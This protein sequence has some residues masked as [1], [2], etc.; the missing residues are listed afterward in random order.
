MKNFILLLLLG[1]S[2]SFAATI[3]DLEKAIY[4]S[5]LEQAEE[6]INQLSISPLDHH[7][8]ID[9][10]Q[11]I[12]RDRQ[13]RTMQD[14]Y[15]GYYHFLDKLT[16]LPLM[17]TLYGTAFT[18]GDWA[19]YFAYYP[20]LSLPVITTLLNISSF[21]LNIYSII[22]TIKNIKKTQQRLNTNYDKAV[23]IKQLLYQARIEPA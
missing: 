13:L 21:C 2:F 4:D 23:K 16:I 14:N 19:N 10:A 6:I 1:T 3:S 22:N 18:I 15:F 9:L 20:K 17:A 8:L 11:E 7:R 12:I 5:N